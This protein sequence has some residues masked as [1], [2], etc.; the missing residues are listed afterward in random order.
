LNNICCPDELLDLVALLLP[1][2]SSTEEPV[3][4]DQSQAILLNELG[5]IERSSLLKLL[6]SNIILRQVKVRGLSVQ[7]Y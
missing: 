5:S 4:A 7:K 3:G 1:T 6:A 2:I